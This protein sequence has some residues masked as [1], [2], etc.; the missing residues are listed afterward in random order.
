[1]DN[2]VQL[3]GPSHPRP[4]WLQ[5]SSPRNLAMDRHF[6]ARGPEGR[7]MM[8]STASVQV[9]LDAGADDADVSERWHALH[10]WLPVLTGLFANSPAAALLQGLGVGQAD[11]TYRA[12]L[13]STLPSCNEAP[14]V[15]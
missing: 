3:S 7:T 6:A 15:E 14:N 4:P 9:C 13:K 8:C 10:A 5:T 1:M 12:T 11:R 2:L